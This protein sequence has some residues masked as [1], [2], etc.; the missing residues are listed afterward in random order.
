[1]SPIDRSVLAERTLAVTRHLDRV[2]AKLP[3]AA[4]DLHAETDASDAVILH[5]WQATQIV[6]DL[7]VSASVVLGGGTPAT[8]GDAFRRLGAAGILD[9]DLAARLVKAAGFRNLVAHAYERLDMRR[10]HH[11]AATGPADLRTCLAALSR[12]AKP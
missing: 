10:V 1:M 6:I 9:A 11:A 2:A 3:P 4:D 5:L 8:Y 12:H 7:A